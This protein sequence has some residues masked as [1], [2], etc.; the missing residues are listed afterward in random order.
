MEPSRYTG[1]AAV[2][3]DAFLKN[4][5]DPMLES[6]KDLLGMTAEINV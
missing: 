3:V 4:V 2:Q 5:V 1:R 6:H